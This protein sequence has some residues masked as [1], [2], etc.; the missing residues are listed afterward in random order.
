MV[1]VRLGVIAVHKVDKSY[2]VK[3]LVRF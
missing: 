3:F 1:M 2:W